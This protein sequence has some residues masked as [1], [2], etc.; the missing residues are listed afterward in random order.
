[1][2]KVARRAADVWSQEGRSPTSRHPGS[3]VDLTSGKYF[4]AAG[5]LWRIEATR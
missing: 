1:M 3:V 5:M 4:R 2:G